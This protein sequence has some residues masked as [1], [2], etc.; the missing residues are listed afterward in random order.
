M[1]LLHIPVNVVYLPIGDQIRLLKADAV[2]P[3]SAISGI[4]SYS[5]Q[6]SLKFSVLELSSYR[7][8]ISN[9]AML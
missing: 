3:I 2:T 8:S 6:S 5:T 9:L 1:H 7:I 4:L